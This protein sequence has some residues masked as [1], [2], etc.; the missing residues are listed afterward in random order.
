MNGRAM[1]PGNKD[2]DDFATYVGWQS[3]HLNCK[4]TRHID[5]FGNFPPL[6]PFTW[7]SLEEFFSFRF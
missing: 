7:R 1:W 4:Y 6:L 5:I 2:T 3:R